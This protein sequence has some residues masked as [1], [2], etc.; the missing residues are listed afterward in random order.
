[1]RAPAPT[2]SEYTPAR[3]IVSRICRDPGVTVRSTS[4]CTERPRRTAATVA[5]S[6]NDELTEL[7]THTCFVAVPETSRTATTFPGDDGSAI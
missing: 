4:G 1:M 3:T 6:S 7:P 2:R 5:R